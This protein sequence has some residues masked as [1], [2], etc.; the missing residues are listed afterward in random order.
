V[1]KQLNQDLESLNS[2]SQAVE[3]ELNSK[4]TDSKDWAF[5]HRSFPIEYEK[6]LLHKTDLGTND[7]LV[8]IIH[9]AALCTGG[10]LAQI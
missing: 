5:N 4:Y 7:I 3:P 6:T 2:L 8:W 1:D 9:G 10:R